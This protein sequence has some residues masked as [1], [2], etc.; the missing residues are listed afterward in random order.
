MADE[1]RARRAV[2]LRIGFGA[3]A[4][5][6]LFHFVDLREVVAALRS[7]APAGL[8]AAA[9]FNIAT[10]CAAAARSYSL[11]RGAK[12]PVSFLQSLQA[13][14]IAN[15]WGLALPGVSAGSVATVLRYRSYGAGMVQSIAVL[16]ASRAVELAAFCLLALVGLAASTNVAG[17]VRPWAAAVLLGAVLACAGLIAL[18]RRRGPWRI[19]VVSSAADVTATTRV[20]RRVCNAL[21][22]LLELLRTLPAGALSQASAWAL[23]QALLDAV[24]VLVLAMALDLPIGLPQALWINALSYLAI[25]LPLSVAGLGMREAAVLAALLPLGISRGDALALALLML[26]MTLLNA[27]AGAAVQLTIRSGVRQSA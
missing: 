4:L 15:F 3:V 7:A 26:T 8:I 10:R 14:F 11:S 18:L 2:A 22:S 24:T 17:G 27:L 19:A 1:N 16:G 5:V 12:L 6:L 13:L 25:L 20:L 21:A 9:A 23:L